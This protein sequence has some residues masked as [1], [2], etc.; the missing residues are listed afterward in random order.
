MKYIFTG[1]S[2]FIGT[3]FTEYLKENIYLN[4][5]IENPII[6]NN[7]LNINI[8]DRKSLLNIKINEDDYTLIHLAA[9]HFDFQKKFY[10]TNVEGTKNVLEFVSKNKIKNF[11]FFSSVA[12]YGNSENGKDENSIK[13]PIN[14][15]GKSKWEAENKIREWH[16]SNLF[17]RVIIVRPAVVFGEY[18]FGNVFNLIRQIKSR[19]YAIVGN[20]ENIKS[21]AYVKNLLGSVIYCLK[22]VNENY[23][24]YNYCDYPQYT[25]SKLSLEISGKLGYRK[26]I[27]IPLIL[28]KFLSLPIDFL[29]KIFKKDLKFNSMRI[30]KFTESTYFVSNRIRDIGYRPQYSNEEALFK[31][32][33]WINKND[34]IKLRNEWYSKARKL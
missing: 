4:I 18:N 3:H 14:D 11:V 20:G 16:K 13:V 1:A 28:T 25:T 30:T 17:C 2:G 12:V 24:E 7:H 27:K 31:T 21:V 23:F 26:S 34:V 8:L 32:L 15:Y 22:T 5:D 29:E 33:S 10:E 19:F 6:K 9:V